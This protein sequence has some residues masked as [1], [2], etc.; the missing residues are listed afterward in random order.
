[1]KRQAFITNPSPSRCA[2]RFRMIEPLRFGV[3]ETGAIYRLGRNE[4]LTP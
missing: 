1:M 2:S 4:E 3:K